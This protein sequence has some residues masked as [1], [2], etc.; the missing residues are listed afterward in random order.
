MIGEHGVP[1]HVYQQ[2]ATELAAGELANLI[3]A[4]AAINA[5]NRIA[6]STSMVFSQLA[7]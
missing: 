7:E 6:V 1:D 3:L 4:I 2:A 5:W